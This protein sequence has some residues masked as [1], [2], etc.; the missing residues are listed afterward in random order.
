VGTEVRCFV[1]FGF[2]FALCAF[3]GVLGWALSG[4]GQGRVAGSLRLHVEIIAMVGR[5]SPVRVGCGR[6]RL[7]TWFRVE[8]RVHAYWVSHPPSPGVSISAEPGLCAVVLMAWSCASCMRT[9]GLGG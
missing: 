7:R 4:M 9:R 1:V 6:V 2:L 3:W 8:I 5:S